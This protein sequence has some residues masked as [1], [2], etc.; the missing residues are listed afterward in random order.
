MPLSQGAVGVA[1]I[2]VGISILGVEADG[3]GI[4]LDGPRILALLRVGAPSVVVGISILRI[5]P[6]RLVEVLDGPLPRLL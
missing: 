4:V 1:P 5:E 6:Y 2:F 3:L